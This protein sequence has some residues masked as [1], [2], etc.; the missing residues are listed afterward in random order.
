[1]AEKYAWSVCAIPHLPK[2]GYQ[3]NISLNIQSVFAF[4]TYNINISCEPRLSK[5]IDILQ[6]SATHSI[7]T[8]YTDI[9]SQCR[10]QMY[11]N[12]Y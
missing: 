1:M 9:H 8:K 6:N 4:N 2:T 7:S 12:A 5:N 3:T 10:Y 11:A